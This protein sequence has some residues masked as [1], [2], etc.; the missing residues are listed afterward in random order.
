MTITVPASDVAGF[1]LQADVTAQTAVNATLA[2]GS[3]H[4]AAAQV[5]LTV[6]KDQLVAYLISTNRITS[7]NILATGTYG[8]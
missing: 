4:L 6:L 2:A 8:V 7:T 1:K 3:T 5:K